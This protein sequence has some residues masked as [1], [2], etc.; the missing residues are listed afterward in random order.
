MDPQ[1]FFAELFS[2]SCTSR[3]CSRKKF[4][5]DAPF[6]EFGGSSSPCRQKKRIVTILETTSRRA[7]G[8]WR[9]DSLPEFGDHIQPAMASF[10][11]NLAAR[12]R[13]RRRATSIGATDFAGVSQMPTDDGPGIYAN[14]SLFFAKLIK[15]QSPI[16]KPLDRCF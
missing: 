14:S 4:S 5:A 8:V 16:A 6:L 15:I 13:R 3:E 9:P 1:N 7:A 10:R 12:R 11:K 2:S